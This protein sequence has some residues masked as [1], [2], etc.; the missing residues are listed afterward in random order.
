MPQHAVYREPQIAEPRTHHADVVR[1]P[2]LLGRAQRR[3]GEEDQP[4]R[5]GAHAESVA[6][7][8]RGAVDGDDDG[9]ARVDAEA[10]EPRPRPRGRGHHLLGAPARPPV[11]EH[12]EP[13]ALQHERT[14]QRHQVPAA[15]VLRR[16]VGEHDGAVGEVH[17]PEVA[18]DGDP[19]RRPG[20]AELP[21][22]PHPVDPV[23]V[24]R[25]DVEGER[26]PRQRRQRV[27]DLAQ[28]R[29]RLEGLR[30]VAVGGEPVQ[31]AVAVAVEQGGRG[32][33]QLEAG[34]AQ[35]PLLVGLCVVIRCLIQAATG[36]GEAQRRHREDGAGQA[37][38]AARCRH[39][40]P[41]A[42]REAPVILSPDAVRP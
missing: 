19:V 8:G 11:A 39:V 24:A 32:V 33:R 38:A 21:A 31:E 35:R 6:H 20:V 37:D 3:M 23:L 42:G 15:Q 29:A 12:D 17:E 13:G 41:G 14:V 18:D 10:G 28:G 1:G 2:V 9:G 30:R 16:L 40:T 34:Q 36:H 5:R 25:R 27:V 7:V 4:G 22:P 26:A